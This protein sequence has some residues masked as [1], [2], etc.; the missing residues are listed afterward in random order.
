MGW[1]VKYTEFL[2]SAKRHNHACRVLKA[3][4]DSFNEDDLRSEEFKFLVLS[5]YYLSGY[6]IECALKFKIFELKQY[7][8]NIEVDEQNCKNAGIEYRKRIR[9][10]KF[11][12]LQNYL[13]SLIGGFS[14]ISNNSEINRLLSEWSPE[15]RYSHFDLEYEK[16]KEFY[17]H[18]SQYLRKM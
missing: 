18:S 2:T 5:L 3:K 9:T 14:H 7:N 13:D 15:I 8:P 1:A 16:V 11:S 6:I 17:A 4:L 12:S 10:H